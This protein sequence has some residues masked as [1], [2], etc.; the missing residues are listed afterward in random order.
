MDILV[1]GQAT[2]ARDEGLESLGDLVAVVEEGVAD[3]GGVGS[4]WTSKGQYFDEHKVGHEINA[5]KTP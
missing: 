2:S 1:C 4:D 5:Q 3:S